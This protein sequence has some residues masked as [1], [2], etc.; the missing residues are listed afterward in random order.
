MFRKLER[1][2]RAF[3]QVKITID[4]VPT[5]A[6]DGE[7]VAA[8]LL[9]SSPHT[10]RATPVS[11]AMRAPFCMMGACFD[12]LVIIDGEN[13]TRSCLVGARNGMTVA[14]QMERPD[15]AQAFA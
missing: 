8:V 1:G 9:R 3:P 13:S 2:D 12:C 10:V 15:P 11:G 14:R 4:G 6:D 7:P 5:Y